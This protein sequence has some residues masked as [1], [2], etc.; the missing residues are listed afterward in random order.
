MTS[1][2]LRVHVRP[3]AGKIVGVSETVPVKP[4]TLSIV[5]VDVPVSPSTI[6]TLVGLVEIAKSNGG[7]TTKVT[8]KECVSGPL[9][10]LTV[11]V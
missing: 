10:P 1:V 6:V 2:G 4:L 5:I 8:P 11:T 7:V 3:W 9:V